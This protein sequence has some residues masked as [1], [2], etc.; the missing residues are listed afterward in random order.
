MQLLNSGMLWTLGAV[1]VPVLLHLSLRRVYRQMHLGTL[2]F[3][4]VSSVPRKRRARLEEILLMLLRMAALAVLALVFL[5]PFLPGTG[6]NPPPAGETV[7]LLDASGSVTEEMAAMARSEAARVMRD[8]RSPVYTLMAFAD[9]V[10]ALSRPDEYL[11]VPGAPT[12]TTAALKW[13]LDHFRQNPTVNGR[14]VLISHLAASQLP[15]A[16]PLIWPPSIPVEVIPLLEKDSNNAAVA[17]VNLLTPFAEREMDV[18]VR[19]AA[20][21]VRKPLTLSLEAEGFKLDQTLPPGKSTCVFRFPVPREIVRGSV[22]VRSRDAWPDD[23]ARPFAFA[24]AARR[25]ILLVDGRPGGTPFEGQPYFI[26]KALAASGAAHGLS[27]FLPETCFGLEDKRGLTDLTPYAAVA[28]CGVGEMLPQT[29]AALTDYVAG[30]GS[31]IFVAA[32]GA[33]ASLKPLAAA[34]LLPGGWRYQE[35]KDPRT[36]ARFERDH[37]AFAAFSNKDYGNLADLPWQCRITPDSGHGWKPLL[38]LDN[39]APLLLEKPR[40]G[41]AGRVMVL[42]HPLNRDWNDLP[43]EPVFVPFVK[44]L[45]GY[46]AGVDHR[47]SEARVIYPGLA[48]K[49]RIGSYSMPDGTVDLVVASPSESATGSADVARFRSAY[50]LPDPAVAAP[51]APPPPDGAPDVS[52]AREWWPWAVVVLLA[53]LMLETWLATRQPK[54]AVS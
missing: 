22:T 30:G 12:E 11:P 45:F 10:Q 51:S 39:A 23:N 20:P 42:L 31:V 36:I 15:A 41:D 53:M 48:E 6:T 37:P 28:L 27:P 17:A 40:T 13:A 2:R 49:R 43:R 5:R 1:A 29:A 4:R 25:K 46:L 38:E 16:V 3:L 9:S 8:G 26:G 18:S 34:G 50:G 7:I 47:P 35:N 54:P 19:V 52:R 24:R 14:V 33:P 21:S 32:D 44:N